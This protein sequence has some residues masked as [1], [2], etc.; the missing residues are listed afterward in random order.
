MPSVFTTAGLALLAQRRQT[1]TPVVIDRIQ[2]GTLAA[3]SRYDATAAATAAVDPTP[4]EFTGDA[5]AFG[6]HQAQVQ[7]DVNIP[8]QAAGGG[9]SE[10]L[11]WVG[12]TLLLI[13]ADQAADFGAF[14]AGQGSL[15]SIAFG[16][17]NAG[18]PGALTVTASARPVATKAEA[19]AGTSNARLMTPLRTHEAIAATRPAPNVQMPVPGRLGFVWR[20]PTGALRVQEIVIDGGSGGNAGEVGGNDQNN[21]G[22]GG[23]GGAGGAMRIRWHNAADLPETAVVS[24][25]SG[26]AGGAGGTR[27][28]ARNGSPGGV[29]S[30]GVTN[31]YAEIVDVGGVTAGAGGAG[32][33]GG[34]YRSGSVTTLQTSGAAGTTSPGG[35]LGAGGAGGNGGNVTP[36]LAFNG[37]DGAAG[38]TAGGGGGGGGGGARNADTS[39]VQEANGGAGGAGAA[40]QVI[41][42]TY[43]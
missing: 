41:I 3:G 30:F 32:G 19:E 18:V 20:K 39:P 33:R 6:V 29:S 27:G 31:V 9:M 23:A 36:T 43:F 42:T 12:S 16:I 10:L 24:V 35:A 28:S 11:A 22:R 5:I 8:V 25:G 37:R 38:T 1:D 40:G 13:R 15:V 17:S 26:G 7:Y 2:I 34:V 21:S 4:R 14:V